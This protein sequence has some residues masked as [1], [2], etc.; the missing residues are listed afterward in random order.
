MDETESRAAPAPLP[1]I[2]PCK[3]CGAEAHTT[4]AIPSA[5]LAA[6]VMCSDYDCGHFEHGKTLTT[7][8]ARWNRRPI[9]TGGR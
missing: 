2:L 3:I 5:N 1:T 6:L 8:A 7:A 4:S 9:P